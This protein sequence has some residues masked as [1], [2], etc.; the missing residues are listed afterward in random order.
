MPLCSSQSL[1]KPIGNFDY[2]NNDEGHKE[3][4]KISP[5]E[6]VQYDDKLIMN[7]KCPLC[8]LTLKLFLHLNLLSQPVLK[9]SPQIHS[10]V[11]VLTVNIQS[12]ASCR[13]PA[14]GPISLS[15]EKH[16]SEHATP[17]LKIL[18]FFQGIKSQFP[19]RIDEV[20]IIMWPI[21][22]SSTLS[23]TPLLLAP[24]Y[25][26]IILSLLNQAF[27]PLPLSL[28]TYLSLHGMHSFCYLI[29]IPQPAPVCFLH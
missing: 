3:Q 11:S 21:Y 2:N 25:T 8:I 4:Y 27:L 7:K 23:L 17:L 20:F 5:Y 22:S 18:I 16:K 12:C 26:N 9:S 29:N 19:R 14:P 28:C 1:F 6:N 24:T 15:N 10:A 13:S